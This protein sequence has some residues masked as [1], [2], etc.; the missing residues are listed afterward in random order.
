MWFNKK[1][2]TLKMDK[3][4]KIKDASTPPL[5]RKEYEQDKKELNR[6]DFI[7]QYSQASG[8]TAEAEDL[9][10]EIYSQD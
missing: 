10:G 8:Q 3:P 9:A 5:S 4:E 2:R 7:Q 6:Q 1:N